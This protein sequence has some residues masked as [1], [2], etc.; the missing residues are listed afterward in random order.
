MGG[1]PVNPYRLLFE[2]CELGRFELPNRIVMAP[3]GSNLATVKGEVTEQ[4]IDHYRARAEGGA[5]LI[6]IEGTSVHGSGRGYPRQLSA[7]DDSF[8][9]G[10]RALAEAIHKA[11][12]RVLLQLHHGGRNTDPRISGRPPL[13]PSPIRSPVGQYTPESMSLDQIELMVEAFGRAAERAREAGFDGVELH[14]AHEYLIHQF[15]TPYC[16]QRTDGYGGELENRLRFPLEIIGRI[17]RRLKESLLSFRL[18]GSDHVAGGLTVDETEEMARRLK[19]AGVDLISVTGGVF[20]TPQLL[21]PPLDTPHGTH[22]ELASRIREATGGPVAGVGRITSPAMAELALK[23][24]QVDL[25]ACARAFLADPGWPAKA[26]TGE[27]RTIRRCVGCNQG[28]IDYFFAGYPI[29]CLYNP[30]AGHDSELA[31]RP[32]KKKRAVVVVG[33]GPAGLEA[34]RVLDLM[35]H[36]VTLLEQEERIGGQVNLALRPPGKGEFKQVIDYYT[37]ALARSRVE[38]MLG[39]RAGPETIRDLSPEAVVVATGALPLEDSMKG[40]PGPNTFSAHQVLGGKVQAGDKV[41]ILGGGNVGLETAHLLLS[42]GR[43]VTVIEMGRQIGQDLGPARRYL[44]MRRLR[45]LKLRRM[46]NCRVRR[47]HSDRVSFI[48][49]KDNGQRVYQELTGVDTF[50]N[51]LGVRPLDDLALELEEEGTIPRERVLLVGDAL[52]PG[53]ILDAVTEGARSGL[54]IEDI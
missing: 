39:I 20:E 23:R 5:G 38:L 31:L 4:L 53:K 2:P 16:N 49:T 47:I 45:E 30:R 26:R 51:A 40:L 17:R 3:M 28:C 42:L 29:T 32:A 48:R 43:K 27:W 18:S 19:A 21:I 15:M 41:V 25:V 7:A 8:L 34:A 10:L 37:Q 46:V 54:R 14:G 36:R 13:G 6:V 44:L 24:G 11:G 1:R 12:A 50:I 9:E 52:N 35:G 33:A 22:L